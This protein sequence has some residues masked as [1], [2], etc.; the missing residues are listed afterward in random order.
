MFSLENAKGILTNNN[1]ETINAIQ[2][3]LDDLYNLCSVLNTYN[4]GI[5]QYRERW[6]CVGF[7]KPIGFN[8]PVRNDVGS[9][10]SVQI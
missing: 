6:Y 9:K 10:I 5:P 7:N 4:F 1:G 2:T 8:F 3:T